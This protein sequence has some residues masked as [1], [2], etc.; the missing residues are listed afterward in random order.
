MPRSISGALTTHLAGTTTTMAMCWKLTRP[1]DGRVW[2]LTNHDKDI[3][4]TG[5]GALNGTYVA[6]AAFTSKTFTFMANLAPSRAELSSVLKD[7]TDTMLTA[8]DIPVEDLRCGLF[9]NSAVEI[10][11]VNF[12]DISQGTLD[13]VKGNWGDVVIVDSRFTVEVR[14]LAERLRKRFVNLFSP[15]CRVDLFSAECGLSAAAFLEDSFVDTVVSQVIIDLPTGASILTRQLDTLADAT[16]ETDTVSQK[17]ATRR[18]A[19]EG[20]TDSGV[21]WTPGTDP[22]PVDLKLDGFPAVLKLVKVTTTEDGTPRRPFL[23]ANTTDFNNIRNNIYACYALTADLD[24]VAF[25]TWTPIPIFYGVID[26]RGHVISNLDSDLVAS[27]LNNALVG[28]LEQGGVIRRLGVEDSD[29]RGTNTTVERAA[30]A[31]VMRPGSLI[32]DCYSFN[33]NFDGNEM[34]GIAS[35]LINGNGT[36]LRDPVILRCWA[37]NIMVTGT[38]GATTNGVV[39]APA[40]GGGV[41]IQNTFG[42]NA[43]SQDNAGVEIASGTSGLN[44][45]DSGSRVFGSTAMQTRATY[46]SGGSQEAPVATAGDMFDTLP[47]APF[48]WGAPWRIDDTNDYPRLIPQDV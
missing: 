38:A 12:E 41:G 31:A 29:F 11:L 4:V 25:G 42:D 15:D 24:F 27:T 28:E 1:F 39:C 33:C 35:D 8:D 40:T 7:V 26:G 10:F 9:D 19:Q 37:A 21:I 45:N 48:L 44:A 2:R 47:L 6:I 13:L 32:A 14:S 16:T 30:F 20:M 3:V 46:T 17:A 5:S 18:I 36:T 34:G 43:Y 23:V 22:D